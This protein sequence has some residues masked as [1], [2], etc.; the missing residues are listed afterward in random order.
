MWHDDRELKVEN[1]ESSR[2]RNGVGGAGRVE[3]VENLPD[4][5]P[6]RV[7]RDAERPDDRLVRGPGSEQCRHLPLACR[8]GQFEID[9]G[10]M[11]LLPDD[12]RVGVLASRQSLV[13]LRSSSA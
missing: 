9:R 8:A 6:D 11:L 13:E 3:R 5:E 12:A 7:D 10:H 2:L 4:M 1:A